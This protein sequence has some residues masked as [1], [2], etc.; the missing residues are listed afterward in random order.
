MRLNAVSFHIV[1]VAALQMS[2][3]PKSLWTFLTSLS[4]IMGFHRKVRRWAQLADRPR[5]RALPGRGG[6]GLGV[7]EAGRVGVL[8]PSEERGLSEGRAGAEEH[9]RCASMTARGGGR[10]GEGG[11]SPLGAAAPGWGGSLC[12]RAPAPPRG[13]RR[14]PRLRLVG[15]AGWRHAPR[16]VTGEPGGVC[17]LLFGG[18]GPSARASVN[19]S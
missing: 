10:G 1:S 7:G 18:T 14:S 2:T 5:P 13:R 4:E 3:G 17:S 12:P 11:G 19:R 15:F 9:V 6:A 8:L 16:D